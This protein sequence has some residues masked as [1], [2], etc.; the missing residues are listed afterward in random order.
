MSGSRGRRSFGEDDGS[1]RRHRLH[2]R[3][4]HTMKSRIL[5]LIFGLLG[6]LAMVAVSL[7]AYTELQWDRRFD[8]PYPE[9]EASTDPEVIE[10]G[11]YL[12]FGP[13]HCAACHTP[14]DRHDVLERGEMTDLVGG[15]EW[16][17]PLGVL[18]SPNITSDAETGIG[19]YSDAEISRTLRHGVKPDGRA[20]FPIMEFQ[21]LS[22]EDLTAIVSYL[23][24]T[25][26]VRQAQPESELTFV[27]RAVM[28]ALIRPSGPSGLP[29]AV[30]PSPGATI[31]RG[32]YLVNNVANCAGCHSQ[33]SMVDG[34]Y[35]GPRLAGG[36]P[37]PLDDDPST[38]LVPPNLTPDPATGQIAS[39]T[40]EQFIA[41]F[42]AGKLHEGT[43]MP[44]VMYATMSDEDL[45]AIY[46]YL[47]SLD[48]VE[49]DIGPIRRPAK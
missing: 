7:A 19:R 10:Q 40:A 32:E 30:S 21:N 24:S 20:T 39:W 44:W 22:D 13:A 38:V 48:P 14:A 12:V 34:S 35:T 8:A 5:K 3:Y 6:I 25:P 37:M 28:A 29:P 11:R 46:G 4:E 15:F 23:R 17:L 49:N 27:G 1:D 33:R 42:R 16:H 9:V 36:S 31:E 2:V 26:P 43:H 18:R 47:M 45:A 41:R